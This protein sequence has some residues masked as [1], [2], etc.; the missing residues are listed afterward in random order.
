MRYVFGDYSLDTQRYELRHVGALMPLG[1]HL[2]ETRATHE[3]AI[4]L[5]LALRPALYPS[6]DFGRLLVVLREAETLAEAFADHRRLAQVSC[7]LAI[8]FYHMGAYDQSIAAAQRALALATASGDVTLHA[9]AHYYLGPAFMAQGNYRRA[10]DCYTQT[11]VSLEGARRH[12]CFG[13]AL[14]P[15]GS[16]RGFQTGAV[17]YVA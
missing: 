13:Q 10:I 3:Q 8:Y 16:T 9:L 6:G 14:L 15:A 17:S 4:D 2:P 11:V 1:P 7:F 5:R 12:E